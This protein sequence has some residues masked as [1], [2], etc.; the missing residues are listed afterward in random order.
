[1]EYDSISIDRFIKFLRIYGYDLVSYWTHTFKSKESGFFNIPMSDEIIY[2]VEEHHFAIICVDSTAYVVNTYGGKFD[3]FV[4]HNNIEILNKS[5][6]NT[7][8]P[9]IFKRI[10]GIIPN[11]G[12]YVHNITLKEYPLLLPRLNDIIVFINYI[13]NNLRL[14]EDIRHVTNILNGVTKHFMKWSQ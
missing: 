2:S 5:L 6:P 8:N 14:Q 9:Q 7:G 4:T 13:I 1:M 3:L 11:K 12:S 10:F